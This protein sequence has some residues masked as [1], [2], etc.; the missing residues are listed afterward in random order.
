[1]LGVQG[2]DL[3]H[4]EPAI[5]KRHEDAHQ[6]SAV[7]DLDGQERIWPAPC[8]ACASMGGPSGILGAAVGA[9]WR[10]ASGELPC[11]TEPVRLEEAC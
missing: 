8:K 11:M 6:L 2:L 5:G 7:S 3:D 9:E 4:V 1:V 10:V